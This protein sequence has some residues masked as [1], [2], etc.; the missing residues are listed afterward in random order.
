MEQ[1]PEAGGVALNASRSYAIVMEWTEDNYSD[2][3]PDRPSCVITGATVEGTI[4]GIREAITGHLALMAEQCDPI[5]EPRA[6][7]TRTEVAA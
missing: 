1:H 4:V 3:V 5:P 2:Y 6:V 7:V